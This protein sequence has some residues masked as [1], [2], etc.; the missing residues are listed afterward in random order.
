MLLGQSSARHNLN[1]ENICRLHSFAVAFVLSVRGWGSL[2]T[3]GS[4]TSANS[5]TSAS[6]DTTNPLD[7]S[8]DSLKL[9]VGQTAKL[10]ANIEMSDGSVRENVSAEW[11]SS[12]TIVATVSDNGLVT[13]RKPGGFNL[14]VTAEGLTA[15]ISGL[16]VVPKPTSWSRS[17]TGAT[18][19]DLPPRITRIRIEGNY[20]GRSE[21]FVVWCGISSDRGGLLVNEILGTSYQ[22]RYSGIHSA[23]RSYGGQGD[24]CRELQIEHSQWVRWTITET[25]P[26]SG[27]SLAVSTG[28]A[29]ADQEA[30]ERLRAQIMR[31]R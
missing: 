31:V 16:R 13:A 28:S 21:N 18:I 6:S 5:D 29:S 17:G 12:N 20:N 24:P 3:N 4:D 26:R 9:E 23:L 15:R 30:V 25:S 11:T 14:R 27:L 22:T 2:N 1:E 19:L 8:A 7:P 10:S